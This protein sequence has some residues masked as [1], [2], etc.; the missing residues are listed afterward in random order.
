MAKIAKKSSQK[1]G[2]GTAATT[3]A[4]AGVTAG[5]PAQK[6]PRSTMLGRK[7]K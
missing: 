6:Y 7:K 5:A 4:N 2:Y 1:L 3:G